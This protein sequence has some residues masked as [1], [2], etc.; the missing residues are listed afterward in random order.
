MIGD[1][2]GTG[3]AEGDG[4]DSLVELSWLDAVRHIGG[5]GSG[6]SRE[7]SLA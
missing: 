4:D 6:D 3:D 7:A 5:D 1:G 2:N